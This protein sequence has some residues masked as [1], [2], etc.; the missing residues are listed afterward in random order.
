[1]FLR[2]KSQ[3]NSDSFCHNNFT[4]IISPKSIARNIKDFS[5][6]FQK[7]V[8]DV[9]GESVGLRSKK[10]SVAEIYTSPKTQNESS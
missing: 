5:S 1:M 4:N 2:M 7:V 3:Q 6:N 9:E 10:L 8:E